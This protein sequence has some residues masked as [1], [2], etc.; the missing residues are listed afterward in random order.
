MYI[1]SFHGLANVTS[2]MLYEKKL[3]RN[4]MPYGKKFPRNWMR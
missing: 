4:W 3:P 1:Y 2:W